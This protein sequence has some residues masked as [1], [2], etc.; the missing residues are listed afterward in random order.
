[1]L[2]RLAREFD[3]DVR[4]AVRQ[5]RR[6]L[7]FTATVVLTLGLGIGAT[8]ALLS[9]VNA[10]L[11]RPLPY[12]NEERVRVFWMD[13]NWRGEEYDFVRERPGVFQSV[14]A[15]STNGGP[16]HPSTNA[17]GNAELLGF[18]VTTSTLFNVLGAHAY[19]GRTF[20][21]GD[22][23]PGA[24]QVIV[25]SYG[26]WKQDLGGTPG[27]I[28]HQILIDGKEVTIVGVMPQRFYFPNPEFRAWRPVQ[29]DPAGSFYHNVGYLT[30]LGR[31]RPGVAPALVQ[32]DLQRLARSLG[33]RFSYTTDFDKTKG[34]GSVPVRAYLLGNVRGTV[35]LLFGA[36]TLLLL[37]AC[38]NAAALILGRTSDRTGELALRTALGA[39][40]LR[41]A[42]Q[43]LTEAL[44]LAL[45]AA[46]LGTAIAVG[47]F[48]ALVASLPLQGGFAQAV[49]MG[50]VTFVAAFV[51]ALVVATSISMT[52]IRN[53]LRGRLDAVG[54]N[55]E[56][57]ES[58]LRRSTHRVHG[59]LVGGQVTLAVLLVAGAIL[60]IRSVERLRALDL[61]FDPRGVATFTLLPSENE[62]AEHRRQFFRD[63]VARV[64]ATPGVV[65]AGLTSR[66][67]VRDGGFQGPVLPEG[68][69]ELEGAKR[70]NSLF[71]TATPAFFRAMG[72]RMREGRGIDS[73][74]VASSLPVT[75]I[76]ES[77][78]RRMWPGQSAI[79]KHLIT[80]YSG[81]M[82][83]R[84]IVGVTVETRMTTMTGEVPFTM[85]VPVEQHTA[86][87]GGVLVV[88]S[89]GNPAS[90]TTA[91]RR[92][93]AE[94]DPQVAV[95]R[96]ETMDQVL[97][98][99]LAQPLRLRFFLTLFGALALSLGAI[100]VY[101]V[102]SYAVARRRA[103]Y[104]IR[105]A[106][107]ATPSRVLGEVFQ[108]GLAPVALGTFAGVIAAF[109]LGR[110]LA[111]V[112]A[113]IQPSDPASIGTAAGLLLLAGALSTLAP[114]LRAGRTNP[115]SA[116]RAE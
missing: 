34:A 32:S 28:G 21:A 86:P 78:A 40:H 30:L 25:I 68:H 83:S 39:G 37:I 93:A 111:G 29:L 48:S 43:I 67:A 108:R 70:P 62:P 38:G 2:A 44:V 15:F 76:S 59:A 63:L 110:V 71:R 27:V 74:D 45:C 112:V 115:A 116:L 31:V 13:Y 105:V 4:Y 65:A 22:D 6:R 10:L 106:L 20:D 89:S 1:V 9:V 33:E 49:T 114:A 16:Y 36:V 101:G 72:M 5:M 64:N 81:T 47:G 69:P 57:S 53:I 94:L 100:G 56:R 24:P 91:V 85:W 92:I 95:A 61:G 50:W 54:L 104:A 11:L 103:E 7:A 60:L 84:T 58:G 109:A 55:R 80:G 3:A 46:M 42:R 19:L 98:T 90:L 102:V 113:G 73:T 79:G 26:M 41:I 88:R 14:A 96:V 17:A 99:A 51:L 18:V 77:F 8:I 87:D 75:L 12:A 66:L 52:P 35:L 107:G 23:R 97:A 82:I